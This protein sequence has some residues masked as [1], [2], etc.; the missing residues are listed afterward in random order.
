[1]QLNTKSLFAHITGYL[2]LAK[3]KWHS[4]LVSSFLSLLVISDGF[5]IHHRIINGVRS[6]TAD[7]PFYVFLEVNSLQCGG[8]L[9]SHRYLAGR[10]RL[11]AHTSP[12]ITWTFDIKIKLWAPNVLP[13]DF[14]LG[15]LKVDCYSCPLCF[16]TIWCKCTSGYWRNRHFQANDNYSA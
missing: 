3:M 16:K 6:N 9:I 15:G 11:L 1:M 2:N 4:A 14:Y 12:R 5:K 13:F 8:S 7:F 10:C